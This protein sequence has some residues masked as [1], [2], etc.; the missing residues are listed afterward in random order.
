MDDKKT[1]VRLSGLTNSTKFT[2]CCG[3][4]VIPNKDVRCPQ[5]KAEIIWIVK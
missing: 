5:C 4:A 1:G 3:L 2:N